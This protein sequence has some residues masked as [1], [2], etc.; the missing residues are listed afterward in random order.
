MTGA[1]AQQHRQHGIGVSVINPG[2]VATPLT[3]QN[4]FPMPALLTPS[5]AADEILAGWASGRFE[6]HFPKRFTWWLKLLSHL[7][8]AAYFRAVRRATGL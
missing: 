7:G 8:D 3:E 2:F 6:I 1:L 5:Q 4:D